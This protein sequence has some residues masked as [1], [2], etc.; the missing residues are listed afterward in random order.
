MQEISGDEDEEFSIGASE[1][2]EGLTGGEGPAGGD[3][4]PGAQV[5]S[6]S[7]M[8]TNPNDSMAPVERTTMVGGGQFETYNEDDERVL[9]SLPVLPFSEQMATRASSHRNTQNN[10]TV[11]NITNNITQQRRKLKSKKAKAAA[12]A[13]GSELGTPGGATASGG[14]ERWEDHLTRPRALPGSAVSGADNTYP[15]TGSGLDKLVHYQYI[16][17]TSP[18]ENEKDFELVLNCLCFISNYLLRSIFDGFRRP[19]IVVYDY[20]LN[21]R[22]SPYRSRVVRKRRS[23]KVCL[24]AASWR[25][26]ALR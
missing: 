2:G 9:D 1:G 22:S 13:G 23:R 8:T 16:A 3:G 4:A 6:L 7:S 14:S 12:G 15:L 11:N 20:I 19:T 17:T 18:E 5:Q 24:R 26:V 10:I 21:H 25:R